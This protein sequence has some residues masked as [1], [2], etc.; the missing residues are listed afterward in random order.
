MPKKARQRRSVP[1]LKETAQN[2]NLQQEVDHLLL[3]NYIPDSVVVDAE[4][5]RESVPGILSHELKTPTTS[6]KGA[7]Q[8]LHQHLRRAKDEQ[9]AAQLEKVD[10]Y[11][12][13]LTRLIDGFLDIA[14]IETGKLSLQLEAFAVDDLIREI[15]E[16]L[17]RITFVQKAHAEV[18]RDRVRTSPV[19]SNLLTNAIKYAPSAQLIEARAVSDGNWVTVSVQDYG[20]GIPQDQ[21]AGIST[22]TNSQEAAPEDISMSM[23]IPPGLCGKNMWGTQSLF[24]C[25]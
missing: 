22:A 9:S 7:L 6:A 19:R 4:V 3:A 1:V 12:N 25:L 5:T 13:R 17:Q 15:C 18:Y 24:H 10:A 23:L 2:N 20:K 21:Q 16:E 11:L 14:T 8:L